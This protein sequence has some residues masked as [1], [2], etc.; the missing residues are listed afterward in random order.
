MAGV[1]FY[2]SGHGFGHASRTIE[3]INALAALRPDLALALRT[4]ASRWLCEL[5]LTAPVAISTVTTD[6]GVVQIDALRPDVEAT[7]ERARAFYAEREA[8]VER[9]AQAI[10]A[11]GASLVVSDVPPVAFAAA[12]RAGVPSIAI[13]N[14]TWDWIY[15]DYE[16]A[17][18]LSAEVSSL[19]RDWQSRAD[20][21]WRLP[22]HGGFEGIHSLRDLPLVA[23]RSRHPRAA[24]RKRL[25]WPDDRPVVLTSFGGVGMKQLPLE[26]AAADGRLLVVGC[27]EPVSETAGAPLCTIAG[28]VALLN[29]RRLYTDGLR[30]EDVVAAVDVVVTKPGYGIIAECAA[31]GAALLYTSRGRFAEYDVL[32]SQMPRWLRTRFIEQ[33]A[34]FAGDW[35]A[36]VEA[37]LTQPPAPEQP[38]VDGAD[39]AARWLAARLS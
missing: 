37:L 33:D 6:I 18:E 5:T 32:V 17:L 11:A 22:M 31:N 20:E 1:L 4:G 15:A 21:G 8:L 2:V 26:R 25:G 36:E 38:R 12:E 39:T 28:G 27:A 14:F 30:Y 3:V 7:L 16:R 10:D 34:L 35:S 19:C 13:S 24:V 9:E 29:E 23:R